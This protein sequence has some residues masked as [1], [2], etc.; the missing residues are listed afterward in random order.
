MYL[1]VD[2]DKIGEV[3]ARHSQVVAAWIFG[4]GKSGKIRPGGDLDIAVLFEKKPDLDAM[5]DLRADLQEALNF[6]EIDL[7]VL[8][9]AHPITCFEAVSG[10]RIYCQDLE[11][12]SEFVSLV[13]REYEDFTALLCD[14]LNLN[15]AREK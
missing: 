11:R 8:N 1:R 2:L 3:M 13:A 14:Y 12:T 5:A 6:D 10:Q 4:S 9:E 7:V 15:T